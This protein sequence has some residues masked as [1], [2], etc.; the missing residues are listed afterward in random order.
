MDVPS[1]YVMSKFNPNDYPIHVE[2]HPVDSIP[3]ALM[4]PTYRV[5]CFRV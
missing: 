4:D 5:Q 3:S 2:A 1:L